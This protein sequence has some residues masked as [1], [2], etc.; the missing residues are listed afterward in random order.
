[1]TPQRALDGSAERARKARVDVLLSTA[2][3]EDRNR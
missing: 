1:M 2:P 3:A